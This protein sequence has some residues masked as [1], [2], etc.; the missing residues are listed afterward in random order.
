MI[1]SITK[2]FTHP[3]RGIACLLLSICFAGIS[4]CGQFFAKST[5]TGS[6]GSSGSGGSTTGD[7]LY[8]ANG[9]TSLNTISGFA[10]SSGL[11]A[12]LS[13]SPYSPGVTP[14][15]LAINPANTLLYVTDPL[16]GIYV[17]SIASNGA[18]TLL[19][20]GAVANVGAESIAIDP[21]GNW[22][23]AMQDQASGTAPIVSVF[24]INSS[25]G[26]LT[27]QGN[28]ITLDTG[29]AGQLA[30]VPST[31]ATTTYLAYATLGTGGIDGLSFNTSTGDL[32]L[33]SV[34]Q[35]SKLAGSYADNGIMANP[36]GTYLFV[37]ETGTNGV[38]T[39]S[40][41]TNGTLSEL[42]TS[43]LANTGS[44]VGAILVDA[45]GSFLY[46]ANSGANP[47]TI[48]AFTISSAGALT[49]VA[50]SPFTTGLAPSSL[51]EDNTKGY[52][53]VACEGGTP[54]MQVFAINATTGALTSSATATT[55]SV[56]PAGALS[57]VATH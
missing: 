57:V 52:L 38:R 49:A 9:N 24:G 6:S 44:G 7:Y 55:G 23:L 27:T 45:T 26:A 12:N 21:S 42:S 25:T 34:H 36:A 31:T 54:D 15:A 5:S 19:N 40:I 20:G 8:V 16:S 32:T 41:N 30:F 2:R 17:Y 37:S 3:G 50:G 18:L 29:S 28:S 10:L 53:A 51:V 39:F 46:V 43:P 35:N 14:Y 33:L 13:G 47:G 22:L 56:S 4:G 1:P 11:L 48:S